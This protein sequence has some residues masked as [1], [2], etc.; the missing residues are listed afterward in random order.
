MNDC[1]GFR[2]TIS[3]IQWH[4]SESPTAIRHRRNSENTLRN[5]AVAY[6]NNLYE[7]LL[8]SPSP[9]MNSAATINLAA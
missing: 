5:R 9:M 8:R 2:S 6:L 4:D 7:T 1:N 3:P